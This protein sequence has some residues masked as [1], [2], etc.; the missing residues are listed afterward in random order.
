MGS[1][2]NYGIVDVVTLVNE[3]HG[4]QQRCVNQHRPWWHEA[5]LSEAFQSY[6]TKRL[7][8]TDGECKQTGRNTAMATWMNFGLRLLDKYIL[9]SWLFQRFLE[10]RIAANARE[11]KP[12]IFCSKSGLD[13]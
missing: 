4:L 8:K 10:S 11:A 6:Q 2:M 1:G 12:P 13:S 9:P 5:S 3:L 7:E